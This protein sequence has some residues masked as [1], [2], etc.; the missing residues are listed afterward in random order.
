MTMLNFPRYSNG[1]NLTAKELW[2][3]QTTPLMAWLPSKHSENTLG[4]KTSLR[5]G[6]GMD[7]AESRLYQAGDEVR[8]IDW[9][10]TARLGK[11]HTK[12]FIEEKHTTQCLFIDLTKSMHFGSQL[13]LKSIQ[14]THIASLLAWLSIKQNS[15]MAAVIYDGYDVIYC[16]P[17]TVKENA[18]TLIATLLMVLQK[19]RNKNTPLSWETALQK[20]Q[21]FIK[22]YKKVILISDFYQLKEKERNIIR[23]WFPTHTLEFICVYDPLEQGQTHYQGSEW[24]SNDTK[25]F[26]IDFSK[27]KN[28]Q[29]LQHQHQ[30]QHTQLLK[31]ALRLQAS[32]RVFTASRPLSEQLP[33][34]NTDA[35]SITSA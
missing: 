19:K 9:H 20:T 2:V 4:T 26:H 34:N 22:K 31:F 14:V 27:K 28:K 30:I 6:S 12:I 3:Y 21:R 13:L 5:F 33:G 7:Y 25:S 8:S 23:Q 1:V 32:V 11:P 17:H 18:Q 24:V 35:T 15:I 10:V 16:R 29:I